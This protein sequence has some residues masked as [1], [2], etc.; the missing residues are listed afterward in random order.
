VFRLALDEYLPGSILNVCHCTF[1]TVKGRDREDLVVR[2]GAVRSKVY[3]NQK[4]TILKMRRLIHR[5]LPMC[6]KLFS[7]FLKAI[8]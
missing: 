6:P 4:T 1:T 7:D 5:P 3:S 8:S 2:F